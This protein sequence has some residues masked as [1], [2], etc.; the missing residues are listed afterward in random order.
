ML[1]PDGTKTC[2][3]CKTSK[4]VTEFYAVGRRTGDGFSGYCRSCTSQ[5]ARK[6]QKDNPEKMQEKWHRD[7]TTATPERKAYIRSAVDRW[8]RDNPERRNAACRTNRL[9][10]KEKDPVLFRVKRAIDQNAQRAKRKGLISDFHTSDW[11]A[12]LEVFEGR[13]PWCGGRP[14]FLDLDHIVSLHRGGHN[15]VGNIS[16]ICRPCN[17]HKSYSDP[18]E[19]ADFMKIDLQELQRKCKVRESLVGGTAA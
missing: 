4:A 9:K 17:S 5:K 15:V 13:C 19:F 12:L 2:P 18:Q 3:L 7:Y 11:F 10:R 16:P 1:N 6:W 8:A 14:P